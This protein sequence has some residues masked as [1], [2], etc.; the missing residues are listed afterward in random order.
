M[1]TNELTAAI[2]ELLKQH[3]PSSYRDLI[4]LAQFFED[5]ADDLR[6]RAANEALSQP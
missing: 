4:A 1:T 2:S 3:A 5:V 6:D